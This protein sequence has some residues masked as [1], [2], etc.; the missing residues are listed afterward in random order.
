MRPKEQIDRWRKLTPKPVTICHLL[1]WPK[2]VSSP[3]T[4]V[5]RPDPDREFLSAWDGTIGQ[6]V[7]S[8]LS[9]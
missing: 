2:M 4:K 8:K 1:F 7:G 9:K 5:F 3:L 6:A